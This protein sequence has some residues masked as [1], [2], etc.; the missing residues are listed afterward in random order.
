MRRYLAGSLCL[1]DSSN[2]AKPVLAALVRDSKGNEA[3][4]GLRGVLPTHRGDHA[5]ALRGYP[6]FEEL[7]KPKE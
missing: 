5:E 7:M 3:P 1:A 2:E 4:L 6:P